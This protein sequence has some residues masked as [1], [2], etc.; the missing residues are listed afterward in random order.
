MSGGCFVGLLQWLSGKVSSYCISIF[1]VD[2]VR[3]MFM[4]HWHILSQPLKLDRS[5]DEWRKKS[6]DALDTVTKMV[7]DIADSHE[8]MAPHLIDALPPSCGYIIQAA[9]KHI[10]DS[11]GLKSDHEF[12]DISKR[13]NASLNQFSHRWVD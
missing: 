7:V 2:L 8:N 3:T 1:H 6:H 12:Q 10:S 9:L 11:P 13:L 5:L 4:L